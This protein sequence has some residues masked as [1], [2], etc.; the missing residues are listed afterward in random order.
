MRKKIISKNT[1]LKWLLSGLLVTCPVMMMYAQDNLLTLSGVVEDEQGEPLIGVTIFLKDRPGTGWITDIDGG[2]SIKAANGDVLVFSY[3]GYDR[4]EYPVKKSESEL[5]ITMETASSELE[6]VVVMGMGS[7]QRRISVVGAVT[8]VDVK[9]IQTPAT[10]IN[11]MLGGRIPGVISLQTSGEPGKNISEFWIRGI[12][13]F[14]ASSGALVLIDGLEGTLNQVDPADV[15][16]FSILKDASA[17]AVYGV[18][19]ANGV[20]LITT[21]RGQEDRLRITVRSNVKLSVLKRMPEYL[22]AYDYAMLANEASIVSGNQPLYSD[23]Q[24]EIIKHGLDPDLFPNVNWRKEILNT[25]SWQNTHYISARGGG[26]VARY[27]MSLGMSTETAAYKQDKASKYRKDVG[28]NTYNYRTNLDI[29]LTK[30]TQVYMGLDGYISINNLPGMQDTQ[31]LW[32]SQAKLT[33][34]TVPTVYSNGMLPAYGREDNISPYVL[35]N[36]TG[37]TSQE[38]YKNMVTIAIS[39]DLKS[40]TPGLTAKVQGAFDNRSYFTERRHKMPNL[41]SSRKRNTSGELIMTR[42]VNA[43][44][45]QYSSTETQWRK[46]HLEANVNYERVLDDDHRLGGLVY[47]YMSSEKNTRYTTSMTAIPQRYQGVSSRLTYGYK[48]TYLIDANF[49]Y[50][51]SENFKKGE[52]FGFFPSVA[53]GWIPTQYTWTQE[54]IPFLSYLKIRA[55]YGTVGNDRISNDRFPYLTIINSN[56]AG[57]WGGSGLIETV[58]G[59][60]NLKWEVAKKA[61][62][63][64]EGKLFNNSLEFVVDVFHDRRDGIFQRRTQLPTWVGSMQMPYGNVGSM[65]SYGTD[66]NISYSHTLNEDMSFTLR[67]NYTYST[68][69]VNNWE[70]PFQRYEYL[71][72]T[73]RPYNVLRGFKAIGLFKDEQEILN[74]PTQFGKV[75][76]GDI[77]YKDIT[78]DGKITDDDRVPLSYSPFPRFMYG[79]GGEFRYRDFTLG[80]LFKG[81]G[82]TDFF[83]HNNGFGYIPFYGGETGNVLAHVKDQKNRWTPAWYSGDPATEKQDVLFP[84][85]HYGSNENNDKYSSFWLANSRYVRLEEV[86]LNYNLKANTLRNALGINSIDLQLVGRNLALW[87]KVKIWDPE[88]ANKNGYEY[89]IPLTVTFQLYINF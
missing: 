27:F 22:D 76:P 2:F 69:M 86:T 54:R 84:R 18:R 70:Q 29:N 20:V 77:K 45:A 79:F 68:T 16:S 43:Y 49:G 57:G 58:V 23:V 42:R 83:M 10:S 65:S 82:N 78:G 71:S 44:D 15:E 7:T 11:N 28:Y 31:L 34:L 21:K 75:R 4:L 25:S 80:V 32:S 14:G 59:A 8:S 64:L 66:G 17:T 39:Q 33:P 55:S 36:H 53:I 87:D 60:D 47:Y 74:S 63:G 52:Q 1:V 38:H 85:L 73:G 50:T 9:D 30:T 24:L 51:G 6:E 41:Y 3:I 5:T 61:D 19:G 12:G 37:M 48:D 88:Q 67:G 89:P 46:Y 56:A 72:Y 81:T 62:V 40:I 26:T 35:L 13:T